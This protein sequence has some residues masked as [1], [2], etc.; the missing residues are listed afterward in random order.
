MSNQRLC[1]W[2]HLNLD[3]SSFIQFHVSKVMFHTSAKFEGVLPKHWICLTSNSSIRASGE[4]SSCYTAL[5]FGMG[6]PEKKRHTLHDSTN[7]VA[8]CSTIVGEVDAKKGSFAS[9]TEE[10]LR[11]SLPKLRSRAFNL[12]FGIAS[13]LWKC[14]HQLGKS[15]PATGLL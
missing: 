10:F 9:K 6:G 7:E 12:R 15:S 14:S 3:G 8:V 13:A 2:T 11:F 1:R 4:R 5:D